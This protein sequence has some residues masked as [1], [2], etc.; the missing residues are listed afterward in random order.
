MEEFRPIVS[1]SIAMDFMKNGYMKFDDVIINENK[2]CYLGRKNIKT[3]LSMY[4]NKIHTSIS[5]LHK[6]GFSDDYRGIFKSQVYEY[7]SAISDNNY[8]YTP[9]L[10][11]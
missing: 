8:S 6:E 9:V 5:Y 7:I 1:D 10:A 2:S 11:R 3:L 4:E